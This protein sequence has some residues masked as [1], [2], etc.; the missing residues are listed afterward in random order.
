LT[1]ARNPSPET[2]AEHLNR[3]GQQVGLADGVITTLTNFA[4]M[5]LPDLCPVCIA[6]CVRQALETNP[7]PANISVTTNFSATIP[8]VMGDAAQLAIVF[9]NLIRNARDAMQRGGQLTIT[10]RHTSGHVAVDVADNGVGIS[11]ENLSRIM[12][13]L[14]STKARGLGL[15]LAIAR[16]ILEKN[17]GTLRVASEVGRGTTFTVQLV[18]AE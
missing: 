17:K 11:P 3:I 1:N 12:D 4:K 7:L 6:S 16:S 10:G 2:T 8:T 5:P 18:A 13:P 14:F 9:G 15:G